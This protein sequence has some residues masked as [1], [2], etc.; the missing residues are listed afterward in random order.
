MKKYNNLEKRF[1]QLTPEWII[2]TSELTEIFN[3]IKKFELAIKFKDKTIKKASS[4]KNEKGEIE[5]LLK[6]TK[7]AIPDF[8]ILKRDDYYKFKKMKENRL[9]GL[10]WIDPFRY[11]NI[12]SG[13]YIEVFGD[14]Y[15]SGDYVQNLSKEEHIK[16]VKEAYKSTNSEVLILWESEI[17]NQW[18]EVCL[19]KIKEFIN[20][21]ED[22]NWNSF[23]NLNEKENIILSKDAINSLLDC[24][25]WRKLGG[26]DQ[27]KVIEELINSYK[28]IE[29]PIPDINI[30]EYDFNRFISWSKGNC[31]KPTIFGN[32]CCRHFIKSIN[33][34]NVKNCRSF[35]EIWNNEDILRKA[36][37]WQFENETGSHNSKRFL[38]AA[39]YKNG[40]RTISNLHPSRVYLWIKKY[41][42]IKPSGIF[43]DP[44][45]GWGGRLLACNSLG[46]KY[47]AIDANKK[48]VEEL[49]EMANY[50]NMDAKIIYGDSSNIN[51][52]KRLLGDE[53]VDLV[54]SSPPYF[55]KEIYSNDEEQSIIKYRDKNEWN[56][57]FLDPMINNCLE[58]LSNDGVILFNIPMDF[59]LEK[60]KKNIDYKLEDFKVNIESAKKVIKERIIKIVKEE[61]EDKEIE[62]IDYVLCKLCNR[63]FKRLKNHLKITH[64]I[65]IEEYLDKFPDSLLIC[66][67]DSNR[68]RNENKD[69][70]NN[71]KYKQRIVYKTPSG[72]IVKK[73]DAW[74]RAWGVENPPEDTIIDASSVD[75]DPWIDKV[76][77]IDYVVCSIC[78]YK[79]NNL[80]R[81]I[82]KEHDINEYKGEIKSQK[83]KDNLSKAAKKSWESRKR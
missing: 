7:V 27:N 15:H 71:R 62:N 50:F 5:W 77:V 72:K 63:R 70:G 31:N 82:K 73:I 29:I 69:K 75:L 54:F 39:C 56:D 43:Y 40:F 79:A 65:S 42:L 32:N 11:L 47:R 81:H 57:K 17:N 35:Y 9:N 20:K 48:L 64:K 76:E 10:E 41:G 18:E 23:D 16:E 45:A 67:K 22:L 36:I 44:C 51:D 4:Y 3:D 38:N 6:E 8:I 13:Y 66:K 80:T 24:S 12:K 52:V 83:C 59:N 25:Y 74:K 1:N 49:N 28:N 14:I 60:I 33:Y 2:S 68:V 61:I 37:R 46:L 53:K 30:A 55:D 34:A 26:Y 19:P 78:G 58:F 21:I